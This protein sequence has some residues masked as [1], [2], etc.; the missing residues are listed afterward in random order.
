V[1]ARSTPA[2]EVLRL[3]GERFTLLDTHR[4]EVAV[5]AEP[6]DALVLELRL[7]WEP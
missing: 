7:L 6:F 2:L 3:D 1:A 4:G 5:H